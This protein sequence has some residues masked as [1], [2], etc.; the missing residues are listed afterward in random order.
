MTEE[1]IATPVS[2]QGRLGFIEIFFGTLVSPVKTF[3]QLSEDCRTDTNHL[4]AAVAL[5]IFVFALDALRLTP[6]NEIGW[7]LFNVPA[8]VSGGITLWLLTAALVSLLAICFGIDSNKCRACFVTL[9][10]SFLPW[11]FTGP[12]ACFWKVL[13]RTHV[14]FMTIP[15]L[16]ILILQ[17]IAIKESFQLKLWRVLLLVLLVPPLFSFLQMMQFLQSLAAVVGSIVG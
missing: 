4:P 14:L 1:A 2:N 15:L 6:P 8:E 13:G 12:I 7:A 16:W 3:R 17:I 10:W 5:V 11:I 9:A